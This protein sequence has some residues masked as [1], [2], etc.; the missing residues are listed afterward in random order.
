MVDVIRQAWT[1]ME[2]GFMF[3]P[4]GDQKLCLP[5]LFFFFSFNIRCLTDLQYST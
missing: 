4:P 1:H 2:S 5:N 3:S